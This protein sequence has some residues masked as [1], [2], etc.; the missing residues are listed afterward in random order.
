[1][2]QQN[3]T[4]LKKILVGRGKDFWHGH[5]EKDKCLREDANG[6]NTERGRTKIIMT[7]IKKQNI[8]TPVRVYNQSWMPS[9]FNDFFDNEWMGKANATAPS[10][11][12]SESDKDYEVELAA[13]GL[14]KDDFGVHINDEGDL[15]INMEKKQHE[16]EK[17]GRKYLR[18]EFSYS[19]FEQTLV[20]PDDVEKKNIKAE[21]KNG[22]LTVTLPK[23][24]SK[25]VEVR[26]QIEVL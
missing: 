1:M 24:D 19:K 9:V 20:L 15:V 13:P 22:V 7:T 8:M 3:E 25:P 4:G 5:C 6:K 11:N 10:I 16:E 2:W 26:Q 18:R 21:V 12:V 14:T 17:K 23:K